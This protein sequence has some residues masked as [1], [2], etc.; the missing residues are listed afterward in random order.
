MNHE[1]TNDERNALG[2]VARLN[3]HQVNEAR[4][5]FDLR[6]HEYLSERTKE[7]LSAFVCPR[8]NTHRKPFYTSGEWCQLPA[9][10]RKRW[11]NTRPQESRVAA[12]VASFCAVLGQTLSQMAPIEMEELGSQL[13]KPVPR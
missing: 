9:D 8:V 6:A 4:L 13:P 7:S 11:P 12:L 3:P 5:A 1:R 10:V 2:V